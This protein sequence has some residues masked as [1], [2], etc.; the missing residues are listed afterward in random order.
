MSNTYLV[1]KLN[2]VEWNAI[3]W[4]KVERY[5]FKL[6]RRI[7]QAS[8]QGKFQLVRKLQRTL[9]RSYY[10]R[11]LATRQ[12][13]QDNSG[14]KTAGIDGVK[15]ISPK[16]RLKLATNLNLKTKPLPARRILIPKANGEKRPL[17][18]PVMRD[19]ACQALVKLVLEPEWEAKFE[20]NSYGFRSG[21]SSH[22]A[23]EAIFNGIRYKAKWVLDAD[24]S[25]CFDKINHEYL[26]NKVNTSPTL[27]RVIKAW[28]KAGWVFEGKKENSDEGTPQGGVISPLLAKIALHGMENRL[29]QYAENLK[30]KGGK[31]A[32]RKRLTFVRYADDF[33]VLHHN[34]EVIDRAK[35]I[36]MNWLGEAGLEI[37]EEKTRITNTNDGFDFLGFNIRQHQVGKYN[38]GKSPHG[39]LLGFKTLIT[40]SKEKIK[41][42]YQKIADVIRSN[43]S[44]SQ[45]KLIFKLNPIIRG[46][47]NYYSTVV[48]KDTF[49]RLDMLVWKRL[50]RWVK[51]RHKNKSLKWIMQKY[52][53]SINNRSWVFSD[54][55]YILRNHSE[56]SI[57]RHVKV[58]G[59]KSPFDGNLSYWGSRLGL[60]PEMPRRVSKLMKIQKGK[61]VHCGLIF[62]DGDSWEVD[63]II[64][65]SK[66]GKDIYENY[67]LLHRHCHD[68]KTSTDG[69]LNSR[70]T[71][72]KG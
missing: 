72:D 66:G 51:R 65:R 4:R 22:D 7:F 16:Q 64:P 13:T 18:I 49:Q 57:V 58:Q 44:S 71:H 55:V 23:I 39:E 32:N 33:V 69:S 46:W 47:S 5:V 60:H 70:R 41:K 68:T 28:L 10:A 42:H 50:E 8:S 67:Q 14:K 25:K 56:T 3:D 43:N 1:E 34:R 21:C 11:L 53:K 17:S 48:S 45:S 2:N 19:R 27:N 36:I 6:Q 52:F 35:Y 37:S 30:E 9:T 24:I 61:C 26:L 54:G 15:S 12:V 29:M 38:S 62:R 59:E 20:P 40:P 31:I 63:H